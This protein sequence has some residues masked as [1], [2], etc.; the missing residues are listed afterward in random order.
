MMDL[1]IKSKSNQKIKEYA[2]LKMPKYAKEAGLVLLEGKR[3][4]FDAYKFGVKFEAVLYADDQQ[5]CGLK[6]E[7]DK[8][9]KVSDLVIDFLCQTKTNQGIV[10]VAHTKRAE[11]CLPKT[12]FLVLDNVSDPGNFGTIVRSAV[13]CGFNT[14]FALN[15]VDAFNDKVIRSTM[16][17]IFK[18]DIIKVGL[19]EVEKLSKNFDL[20]CADMDGENVFLHKHKKSPFGLVLGN[21]ANGVSDNVRFLCSDCVSLPMENDVESLNVAVSASVLMYILKNN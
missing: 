16:G 15:C 4:I 19:E 7:E 12:N 5:I 11:F 10:A 2:K 21:E 1:V 13:A 3:L 9:I 20:I 6:I 8:L 14:I 17:T 18:C